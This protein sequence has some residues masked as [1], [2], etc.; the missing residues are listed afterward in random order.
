MPT[1]GEAFV[2]IGLGVL[3]QLTVQ[4]LKANGCRVMA[5]D[6]DQA[7]VGMALKMGADVGIR[8][9]QDS[10]IEQVIRITDGIGADGVI[11]T[12]ATPSHEPVSQAFKMCRKKGRVVVVGDVGLNLNRADIYKK[13]LDFFISTSYGP[14]RYDRN[15]EE[16]GLDYPVAWVRWT[17]NRNMAEYLRLIS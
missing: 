1:L 17:E 7:R 13:E 16:K 6:V 15:Y 11:I 8:P 14:G 4:M 3:G 12:A 9:D 5:A 10:D 2:V